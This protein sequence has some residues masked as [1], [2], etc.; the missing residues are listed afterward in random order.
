MVVNIISFNARGLNEELKRRAIFDH[1]RRRCDVFCIQET[2]ATESSANLWKHEWGGPAYFDNGESNSRGVAILI[3]KGLNCTTKDPTSHNNGR[4]CAVTIR[5]EE[6]E[7]RICNVY[8][9]NGDSPGFFSDIFD[10]EKCILMWL[11]NPSIE[12]T[13]AKSTKRARCK[14]SER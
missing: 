13:N 5:H 3:R 11:L 1:Y 2:H 4:F 9:L 7:V 6:K 8:G 14:C 10:K 12:I